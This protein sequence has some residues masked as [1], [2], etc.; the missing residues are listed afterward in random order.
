MDW[1]NNLIF[2]SSAANSIL[3]LA[4]VIC[5]GLVLGKIK[6]AGVGIGVAW[7]LF[8][9]II[10]GHFGLQIPAIVL[11]FVKDFGL[12]L[13]VCSIGLQ[14]GP[15][16]F[17][18]FRASGVKL[19]LLA[20]VIVFSGV[21]VTVAFIFCCS[22]PSE[23]LVGI[24]SGAVTNTPALGAA[25][26]TFADT[27]GRENPNI[28][29]GYASAY[30]MGV[31]G[32]IGSMM[33]FG[34]LFRKF[35]GNA[36]FEGEVRKAIGNEPA[37]VSVE[38]ANP[39]IFGK[40]IGQIF[41]DSNRHFVIS[42]ICQDSKISPANKDMVLNG[43]DKVLII[44]DA[45][46]IDYFVSYFGKK[47][48]F[49]W[50]KIDTQIM[51]AKFVV[52]SPKL[53][54]KTLL[55][56]GLFGAAAFNVTRIN[57]AGTDITAHADFKLHLGDRLT[58]VGSKEAIGRVEKI[59]GNSVKKLDAP[60]LAPMF[61][62]IVFGVILGSIPVWFPAVPQPIKLGLAGGPLVAAILVGY[63]APRFK[64]ATYISNSASLMAREIGISLFL[65]AVGIGA[66]GNFFGT[67]F[68]ANGGKWFLIGCAITLIP[69]FIAFIAGRF[70]LKLDYYS[71]IGVISG[72][73]TNPP[74]LAYAN[75]T[76]TD[77]VVAESY[78]TV[79]PLSM[80]LRVLTAQLLILFFL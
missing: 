25:S 68:S 11:A 66:G 37:R 5:A 56:L 55:S 7:I 31:L 48:D 36:A 42:R 78:A 76:T 28:A 39:G 63:Y 50:R 9:G 59:V 47:I 20:A 23:V 3:V 44:T 17:S 21:A 60:N 52:S 19:N 41:A 15:S 4:F 58:V 51:D 62:A 35:I 72:A 46:D 33:L 16:F 43:G 6:V 2:Q 24:M 38:V 65:C 57:R 13:F 27:V 70:L 79:Y 54:G 22:V 32:V 8:A 77:S 53:E 40:T 1:L 75:S 67:I 64:I 80:F 49:Q 26:Q 61:A 73:T 10:I 45:K 14:V 29:L 74:A 69:M 71:I 12:I 30:P 34:I 18:L